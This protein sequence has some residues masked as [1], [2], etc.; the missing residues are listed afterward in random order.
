MASE[1]LL[2]ILRNDIDDLTDEEL[3]LVIAFALA[4]RDQHTQ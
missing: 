1:Q 4:L 2:A 3:E